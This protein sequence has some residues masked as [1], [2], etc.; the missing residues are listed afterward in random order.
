V[1]ARDASGNVTKLRAHV[2][3]GSK[4]L[5]VIHWV[6]AATSVAA[7]VRLYG[8]L[9][10]VPQPEE[11]GGD[12]LEHL[13][14]AS[15]EVIEGARV[16]QSLAKA[17]VGSRWQLER[18]G[19][20]RIDEDTR[21]GMLV[22]NRISTLREAVVAREVA[23]PAEKKEN[24]KAKTRPKSKS[25]AE[26][27]EEAR[28]RDPFLRETFD[29]AKTMGLPD[30]QADLLS[31]DAATARLFREASK[32]VPGALAAKWIINE[33]PRALAGR[34]VDAIE[35]AR[36]GELMQLLHE[37][38]LTPAVGK[39]AL[40]EMIATGKR[41]SEL[42]ISE[43]KPV[44]LGPVVDAVIAANPDKAAQYKAG[45]TGLLGFFVG[46]VMKSSPGADAAQV[47]QAVRD[48]LG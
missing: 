5:A 40:A 21:P 37:S 43:A 45:K 28:H 34:E 31:G 30:D 23:A 4:G 15:L 32:A 33:L 9:F 14:P 16:E 48:R 3:E 12:F 24:A 22:L 39:T 42:T 20:F 7:E 1:V 27:R 10:K 18:V 19:Y 46:Q 44:D 38:K 2:V 29:A 35:P 47:N 25:P 11:G 41:V 8:R 36:F 13:D 6:D 26:Y 17:E